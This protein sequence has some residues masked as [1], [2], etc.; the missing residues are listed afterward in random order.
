MSRTKDDL[1]IYLLDGFLAIALLV[2][3]FVSWAKFKEGSLVVGEV[4][5]LIRDASRIPIKS[6]GFCNGIL[7]L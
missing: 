6:F 1:A 5:P 7:E 3:G 2:S 4:V